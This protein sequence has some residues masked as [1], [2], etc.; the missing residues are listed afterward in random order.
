MH[1]DIVRKQGHWN[2]FIVFPY[3]FNGGHEINVAGGKNDMVIFQC[4]KNEVRG[5]GDINLPLNPSFLG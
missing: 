4:V 2:F 3:H 1:T 5:D